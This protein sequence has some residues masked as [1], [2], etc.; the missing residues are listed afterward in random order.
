MRVNKRWLVLFLLAAVL[1][2]MMGCGFISKLRARD[3]LNKGVKAYTAQQYDDAAKYFEASIEQDPEFEVA[4]MYLATTYSTQFVPGSPEPRSAQ[5]ADKAIATFKDVAA[6]NPAAP[7]IN[8]MLSVASLYYQLKKYDESKDWCRKIQ[9]VDPQNAESLYRIAVINFDDSLAKTG[10]QGENVEFLNAEEKAHT[11]QEID[12][13]L[14]CLDQALKIKPNYFD[15]MEYENLLWRE[16]AK[17]EKDEK[18]KQ[19]IIR[20]ADKVA[21]TALALR[22]K[23]QEEE[24]KKP[25]KLGTSK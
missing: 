23:S 13:A 2:L 5:M 17:F 3:N 11:Q 14:K 12:E 22:L 9:Q 21:Q 19:E 25:K 16:K 7:N 4:R 15:A 6:K 20:Q 24:A 8:A 10:L 18:T 1:P